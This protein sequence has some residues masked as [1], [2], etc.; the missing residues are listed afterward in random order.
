MTTQ[1]AWT[2]AD[3]E[4]V[5][6]ASFGMTDIVRRC[7]HLAPWDLDDAEPYPG[8]LFVVRAPQLQRIASNIPRRRDT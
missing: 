3:L 5:R 6:W 7:N 1:S 8:S 2:A 4:L